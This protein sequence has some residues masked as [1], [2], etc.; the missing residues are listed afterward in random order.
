MMV[1]LLD[2]Q[3]SLRTSTSWSSRTP[4]GNFRTIGGRRGPLGVRVGGGDLRGESASKNLEIR[5][6]V[7]AVS[8]SQWWWL[9]DATEVNQDGG[10]GDAPRP[11][12]RL[13]SC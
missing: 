9:S 12:V 6:H 11:A 8:I 2:S 10:P 3:P 4:S 5:K 1:E 7:S 13:Q